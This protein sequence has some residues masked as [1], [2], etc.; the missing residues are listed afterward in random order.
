MD[1]HWRYNCEDCVRTFEVAEVERGIITQLGL[2]EPEAAQQAMF[3]PVLAAMTR[4]VRIDIAA[5]SKMA[6]ELFE[7]M[8]KREQYL[9]DVLGHTLNP[10]SF[11][12]MSKLFYTDLAQKVI[13]KR[14]KKGIP[15]R[16]TLDDDALDLIA[17]REPIL[18]PLIKCINEYRSLGVFLG[19]FVRAP[20][21]EDQRMRCGYNICGTETYRLSSSRNA[22]DSGTNLQNIPKG[23]KGTEPDDLDLPNIR[24][25][26][27][28]DPGYTFFDLDL[29]RADLQVVVW[30]ADDR[31][32]KAALK[33]GIDTHCMNACDIY[34]IKGI[35]YEELSPTHP[36]YPNHRGRIT[37]A[38][39]QTAKAGVHATNYGVKERTLAATLGT[40]T[41]EASTFIRS[42][43]VAHPGIQRWHERVAH[44]LQTK[45]FVENRFGYRRFYFS[46]I[47]SV[48]SEALAWQP[49]S[50]V[51]LVIN[52]IWRA[53]FEA[54]VGIEV[55]LQVHDSINGQFLTQSR[56]ESLRTIMAAA[57][58]IIPYEDELT[59][60]VGIKTSVVSWGDCE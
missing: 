52:K 45:R 19:T 46:R 49:Q 3:Y 33:L 57:R 34:H 53:I 36:N 29:D 13:I 9:I 50:T 12:Q 37:D 10:R 56:D 7:E 54:K 55:L 41:H 48:L 30:E 22:F 51:A 16:P 1:A 42:W 59:I 24:K 23:I 38:R 5:R 43:L 40:T 31:D 58:V 25:L 44:Q 39:R 11:P 60:P 15:G 8:Q 26:F 20:L 14:G 18:R 28:P 27:I 6:S 17:I 4:G 35:P 21:D 32:L 47:D 2:S